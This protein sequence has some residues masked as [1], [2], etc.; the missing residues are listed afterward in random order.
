MWRY[1]DNLRALSEV[2][3]LFPECELGAMPPFGPPIH[4]YL[5][6]ALVAYAVIPHGIKEID[7][8]RK[9]T[10]SGS[11]PAMNPLT[12]GVTNLDPSVRA[13]PRPGTGRVTRRAAAFCNTRTK[14]AGVIQRWASSGCEHIAI[15]HHV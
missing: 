7:I 4:E 12:S 14:Q 10:I 5:G 2:R 9:R 13:G 3:D 15:A 6:Q 1:S 11:Y 8:S